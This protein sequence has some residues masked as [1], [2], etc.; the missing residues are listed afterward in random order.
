MTST[1]GGRKYV[2]KGKK[3]KDVYL[4][5]LK[6][7]NTATD[8]IELSSVPE[9]RADLVANQVELVWLPRYLLPYKIKVD[10]G[11]ESKPLIPCATS[12]RLKNRI[13]FHYGAVCHR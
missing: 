5:T 12:P 11:K 4:Q 6:M 7:I 8:W 13:K 10:I 3:D 9:A 1:I 2:L